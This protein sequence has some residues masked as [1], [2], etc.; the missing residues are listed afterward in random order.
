MRRRRAVAVLAMTLAAAA[1]VRLLATR[2]RAATHAPVTQ[3]SRAARNVALARLGASVGSSYATLHARKLFASAARREQLDAEFQLRTAE[4]VATRLGQMKGALMKLGQMASYVDDGLPESVRTTLATLQT[5]A[6]PM[7]AELAAEVITA[8]LG[9]PPEELFAE[10]DPVPIAAAS[11]GQV[12]RAVLAD[13]DGS[14]E[15]AVA[16]KVQYPGVAEAIAADLRNTELLATLLR[17]GFPGLD[18]SGLVDELNERLIEELDYRREAANQQR[19]AEFF[20]GH[21][22]IRIPAIVAELSTARVITSEL[23]VGADWATARQ[24][25]QHQR[26]LIGETMYRF[27]FRSLYRLQAFNGDPHPGN[28]IFHGDGVITFL[29]FGLVRYFS[30]DEIAMFADLVRASAHDRDNVALRRV[31]EDAGLLRRDADVTDDEVGRYF[32]FYAAPSFSEHTTW[33]PSHASKVVRHLFDHNNRLAP[34]LTVPRPF[35]LIQR[36]NMGLFALLGELGAG[37]PYLRIAQE[38]W[39]FTPDDP[40]TPMGER[41]QAWLARLPGR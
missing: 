6:P 13:R 25:D 14:G 39:P 26:D 5:S 12:H 20:A 3:Q 2:R 34:Y 33:T 11:I 21:P 18:P 27:V 30:D 28:Y 35:V 37:G 9:A 22:T 7:S 10:W 16:V 8:E 19:F 17:Q 23:V 41:E 1:A 31:V 38:L 36:I 24:W 29:D 4:D 32:Q 40:A 15:R